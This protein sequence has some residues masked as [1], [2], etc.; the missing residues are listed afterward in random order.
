MEELIEYFNS[1]IKRVYDV[2]E[3]FKDFFGEDRVDLQNVIKFEDLSKKGTKADIDKAIKDIDDSCSSPD[4]YAPNFNNRHLP[5]ILVYFDKVTIKNEYDVSREL[6]KLYVKVILEYS[7]KIRGRFLINRAEYTYKEFI[8]NYMHSHISS[9][10]ISNM[11]EFQTPC[12]GSGPINRTISSLCVDYNEDLWRLFCVEVDK[13]MAVESIAG[14]PYHRMDSIGTAMTGRSYEVCRDVNSDNPSY[15]AYFNKISHHGREVINSFIE[16]LIKNANF[17]YKYSKGYYI[18][19]TPKEIHLK[20]TNNFIK[21]YNYNKKIKNPIIDFNLADLLRG[22]ILIKARYH[23]GRFMVDSG[24]G[25]R[26]LDLISS[27][28]G[29][30]VCTF[31]GE[32]I[33]VH[34]VND[35]EGASSENDAIYLLKDQFTGAIIRLL[36]NTLNFAYGNSEFI[37]ETHSGDAGACKE[38]NIFIL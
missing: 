2:Y 36:Q 11:S 34:F 7:G 17:K 1:K 27:Y 13:F 21:W 22:D 4:R 10:P 15:I 35:L 8:S 28:E 24:G 25:T 33:R 23:N 37:G 20:V 30:P 14:T 31:K 32:L 9:I 6:T 3:I 18:A 19:G 38:N 5:F 12:T 26:S 16:Y 29:V